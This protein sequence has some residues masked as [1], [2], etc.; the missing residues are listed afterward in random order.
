MQYF[1]DDYE[2]KGKS[3]EYTVNKNMRQEDQE[4]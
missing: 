4:M 3:K 2:V 1:I